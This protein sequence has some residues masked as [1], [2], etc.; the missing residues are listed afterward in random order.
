MRE[1]RRGEREMRERGGGRERVGG[2]EEESEREE[3]VRKRD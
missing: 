3:I 1:G 2:I